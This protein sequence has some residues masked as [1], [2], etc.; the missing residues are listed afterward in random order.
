[1]RLLQPP[2]LSGFLAGVLTGLLLSATSVL[3][4]WYLPAGTPAAAARSPG[5]APSSGTE[6]RADPVHILLLGVDERPGDPGRSDTMFLARVGDGSVRLLSIPRDT[7]VTIKGYGEGKAN[8]AYTYGG[9]E[10]A[11]QTVGRLLGIPVDYYVKVNMAGFRHLVDL[12]GGVE[13]HVPKAMRYY[14]PVDG[15]V[16]DLKPGR[17][18]LDGQKA[19]QLVRFRY[20]EIGD[21]VGR[22]HRQQAFL[23]AAAAQ[24]LTPANL[25]RLPQLLYTARQYV[26]TDIPAAVQLRLAYAVYTAQQKDALVQ[27]TLPGHGT[28]IDSISF[29]VVDQEALARLLQAWHAGE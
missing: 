2:R 8:S 20:D 16:I 18:L 5:A 26:E 27:E 9:P 12:M 23:K 21:D 15:L 28:Y 13:F 3:A 25:P 17:Q 4:W 7:L 19:E 10:L 1:M 22:I 11:K 29:Y 14:D 6:V 24:A